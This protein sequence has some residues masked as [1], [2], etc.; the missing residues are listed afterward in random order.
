MYPPSIAVV[1][2]QVDTAPLADSPVADGPDVTGPVV[3]AAP[4]ASTTLPLSFDV[5]IQGA[6][7]GMNMAVSVTDNV[8]TIQIGPD[9]FPVIVYEQ[10][11]WSGF[12]L[13]L[14]QAVAVLPDRWAVM[15]FYCTGAT[16]G[17]VDYED[18]L[19]APLATYTA[20]GTCSVTMQNVNTPIQTSASTLALNSLV[21][22]FRIYGLAT[23]VVRWLSTGSDV[24]R[25]QV[26]ASLSVRSH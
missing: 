13:T 14:Y 6:I 19:G 24:A 1:Q 3:R 26:M 20:T 15:W 25:R 5:D 22:G 2:D 10:I 23:A 7:T 11:P 21:Q 12:S 9:T 17:T 4:A 16:L 18:T 8:G